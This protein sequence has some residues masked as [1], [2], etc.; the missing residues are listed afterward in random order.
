MSGLLSIAARAMFANQAALQTV[1]QNIAN[2]NTPGYSRQSVV[3]TPSPGQFTGAGFFG[4]GVDVQTVERAHNDFLTKQAIDAKATASGDTTQ[5]EQLT[6]LEKIFPTG[7]DGLGHAVSQFLNSMMDVASRPSDL[8][9]RQVVLGQA[10]QLAT[11]FASAG[12]QLAGLQAGVTSDLQAGVTLVNQLAQQLASVNDKIAKVKGSGHLPNDLMDQRDQLISQLSEHVALTTLP[13]DDGTVGVFV[14]GGQRLV[15]GASAL[16]L[17]I[18]PDSYDP[19]RSALAV[20]EGWATRLLDE[21]VLTGG[22]LSALL[23]FQNHDLQ[24]ARHM[25][26]QL[27]ATLG[28]RVNAQNALGLDLSTP[29][30]N[31]API[32]DVAAPRVLPSANNQRN[33]SGS[34]ANGVQATIVDP[35]QLQASAYKLSAGTAPGTYQLTRLSD[36]LVRSVAAGATIDGFNIN[37][38]PSPPAAGDSYVIEPVGAA[39]ANMR[40]VLDSPNGIAAA[41]PVT[42][43]TSVNN[44]GTASVDSIYVV[45]SNFNAATL[46]ISIAFGSSNPDGSVNYTLTPAIGGP[47]PGVW[48]PSQPIGNQ[49][50]A[51]PPINLGFEL[52]LNGVPSAGDTLSVAATRF[53]G[54]NNGNAKAFLDIQTDPFV[55]K[56]LQP[57]GSLLVGATLN[58]AYS[59]VLSDI[60]ARVQGANYLSGVSTSVASAAETS[61]STQSGVNLDEEASRLIQYQQAYQASAKVLQTAQTLFNELLQIASK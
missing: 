13:A 37:F 34:F 2:A 7:N 53:P 14:G 36:G 38:S 40:R 9:A 12:S 35:S 29:P 45:N 20:D 33:P 50:G 11:R 44:T 54:A 42:A 23:K 49:P 15:L 25:V 21:T 19:Q 6:R 51:A 48:K 59:N 16:T 43:V 27:A 22:S 58:D 17:K 39:A 1:G 52:R 26:G 24:D 10:Q 55:G 4:R 8:S 41:S 32:F 28:T 46:P 30:G 5:A 47:I 56:K 31:G 61:R 18:A 3:L 60:G 57:G